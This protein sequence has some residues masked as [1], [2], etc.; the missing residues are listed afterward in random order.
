M[1]FALTVIVAA[2]HAAAVEDTYS[3][4]TANELKKALYTREISCDGCDK[5]ML[6]AKVRENAY[7]PIDLELEELYDEEQH[8]QRK[9]EKFNVTKEE[10]IQQMNTTD[11]QALD[12]DRAERMWT[13]FQAQME[14]GSVV[15]LAN[16]SLS[17]SM[18]FTHHFAS[19][20]PP[21]VCDAI[22]TGYLAARRLY[23][24]QIPKKYRR[25]LESRVDALCT[26][27]ALHALLVVLVGLLLV[28]FAIS[29][30]SSAP[31]AAE[32]P[33]PVKGKAKGKKGD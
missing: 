21:A 26:T 31:P 19:Y 11:G 22:E 10:F 1:R 15:F 4:A 8:F 27:G 6:E 24:Q 20:L 14:T 5:K 28:D 16:G 33:P 29:F 30:T 9:A 12:K 13:Y 7:L 32:S 18:P 23:V 3:R 25:R 2:I 17:F